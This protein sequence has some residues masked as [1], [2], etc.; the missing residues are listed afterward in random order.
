MWSTQPP[1]ALPSVNLWDHTNNFILFNCCN[2]YLRQHPLYLVSWPVLNVSNPAAFS[3][4]LGH[5]ITV[6]PTEGEAVK[7]YLLY[8]KFSSI[9]EIDV[10]RIVLKV[11]NGTVKRINGTERINGTLNLTAGAFSCVSHTGPD[12]APLRAPK[13]LILSLIS[14]CKLSIF[15]ITELDTQ[16][17]DTYPWTWHMALL[18]VLH[19][20]L[21]CTDGAVSCIMHTLEF[22]RWHC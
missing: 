2:W 10:L 16:L 12:Q 9:N 18:A 1:Y 7:K 20:P 19:I 15:H 21:N 22:D 14:E 13:T 8:K 6:H 17:Y 5:C 4:R 3:P 11:I